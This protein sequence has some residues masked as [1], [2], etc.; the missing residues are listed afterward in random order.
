MNTIK[1][2]STSIKSISKWL[3]SENAISWC[4]DIINYK[5]LTSKLA[6]IFMLKYKS[7]NAQLFTFSVSFFVISFV[8]VQRL[9]QL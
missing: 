9:E 6:S 3:L 8:D 7:L 1:H 5:E 2:K 4:L